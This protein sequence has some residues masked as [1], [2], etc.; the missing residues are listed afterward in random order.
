MP[1][2][3]VLLQRNSNATALATIKSPSTTICSQCD[4]P[5][6]EKVNCWWNPDNPE[7]KLGRGNKGGGAKQ[8]ENN[9]NTNPD[10]EK[11]KERVS[12]HKPRE[13][14]LQTLKIKE[15]QNTHA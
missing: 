9:A 5:G 1:T 12:P 8:R 11:S 10:A 7:N 3:A 2:K 6:H 14:A 13:A 15:G 4:R